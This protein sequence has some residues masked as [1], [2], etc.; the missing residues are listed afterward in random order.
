MSTTTDPDRDTRM[1]ARDAEGAVIAYAIDRLYLG[2]RS[3][4]SVLWLMPVVLGIVL[5]DVVDHRTLGLWIIVM[6]CIHVSRMVLVFAYGRRQRRDDAR[7]WA[8]YFAL[9]S[10]AAGIAW[11]SGGMLFFVPGAVGAQVLLYTCIIGLAAGSIVVTSYWLP[12][13]YALAI[14]SV[15]MSALRAAMEG[16]PQYQGL[17]VLLLMYLVI[18]ARVAQNQ[19]RSAYEAVRLRY[20][21]LDLVE[22]LR[23]QKEAAE[24]ANVAK[25]RFL[26]AASHDLRQPLHALQLF[27]TTLSERVRDAELHVIVGGVQRSVSALSELFNALLDVS[28]LDA[29]ILKPKPR[30]FRLADLIGQLELEFQP[31]A[32]AKGLQW[33]VCAG[34]HVLHSDPVLLETMLRNLLSNAL[35]YTLQG[36]IE[37]NARPAAGVL[38]IAVRDTGIGIAPEHRERVFSEFFQVGNPERDRNRGLGLGLAIVQRLARLLDHPLILETEL[39]TGSCFTVRIPLGTCSAGMAAEPPVPGITDLTGLRVLVIDDEREVREGMYSLLAGWGCSVTLCADQDEALQAVAGAAPRPHAIVADY[40]LRDHKTGADA[41]NRLRACLNTPLPGLLITGD[42]APERLREA[43]ASGYALLHK[44]V[45]PARL[46]AFLSSVN[47]SRS[48]GDSTGVPHDTPQG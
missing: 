46:R 44:P 1:P 23:G 7:R 12:A 27:V 18:I 9:T 30:D 31:Q 13:Y 6:L 10:L 25:S 33:R 43:Q 19:K 35:R 21:N 22:Q 32:L 36:A 29:G 34:D 40:R 39:G 11:G 20:E 47:D 4:F 14:P 28:R 5:W 16:T 2:L 8:W 38:D 26:A 42:T 17:A 41:M 48:G 37:I 24:Q 45:P 15:G 3:I